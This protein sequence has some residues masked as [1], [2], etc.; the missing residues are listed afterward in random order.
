MASAILC[1]IFLRLTILKLVCTSNLYTVS[2]E[3]SMINSQFDLPFSKL[4]LNKYLV[5]RVSFYWVL[6]ITLERRL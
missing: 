4:L 1:S 3:Q 2:E 6:E 5:K